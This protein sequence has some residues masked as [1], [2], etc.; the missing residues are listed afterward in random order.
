MQKEFEDDDK[1][2]S[3]AQ[4]HMIVGIGGFFMAIIVTTAA[5]VSVTNYIMPSSG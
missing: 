3:D 5:Y 2:F 1:L 4:H